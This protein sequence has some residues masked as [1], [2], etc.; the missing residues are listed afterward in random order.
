MRIRITVESDAGEKLVEYLQRAD[1]NSDVQF[2][3]PKMPAA[4][5]MR[6]HIL[7]VKTQTSVEPPG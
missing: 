1:H 7:T 6:L 3:E 4:D 2:F 5:G